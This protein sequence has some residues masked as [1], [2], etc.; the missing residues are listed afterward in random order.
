MKNPLG[1]HALVWSG[2]WQK[3]DIDYAIGNSSKL[4]FDLIEIPL[5]NPYKFDLLRFLPYLKLYI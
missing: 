3:S 2:H 4:G 5:L 1:I